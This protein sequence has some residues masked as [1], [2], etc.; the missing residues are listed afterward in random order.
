MMKSEMSSA[1]KL[2][3]P[4]R[5]SILMALQGMLAEAG[6][7]DNLSIEI[8][9]AIAPPPPATGEGQD[10]NQPRSVEA[11]LREISNV[12]ASIEIRLTS[13]YAKIGQA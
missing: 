8:E 9:H 1:S 5:P 2:P 4:E 12:L 10:V 6:R 3:Q 13:T 7:I 11:Y